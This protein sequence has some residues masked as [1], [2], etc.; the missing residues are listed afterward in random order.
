MWENRH[1]STMLQESGLLT[2]LLRSAWHN[3]LPLYIYG[4]PAYPLS[5]HL[6]APFSRRNL[7]PNPVNYNKTMSQTPVSVEWLFNEIK[8][9]FKFV[10]LKSQMKIGLNAAG[11]ICCVC[12]LLQNERTCFMGIIFL[13]FLS[14]FA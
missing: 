5:I 6:L 12:A 9:Y 10:S 11:K 2:I 14:S 13:S 4:D 8:T 7:T 3:N 1:D